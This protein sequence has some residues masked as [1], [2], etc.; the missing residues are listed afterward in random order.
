MCFVRQVFIALFVEPKDDV[1]NIYNQLVETHN[2]KLNYYSKAVNDACF[3]YA[4]MKLIKD[5]EDNGVSGKPQI[6]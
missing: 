1:E 5:Y 3:M 4:L 2:A 6:Y